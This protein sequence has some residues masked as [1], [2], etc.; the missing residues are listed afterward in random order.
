MRRKRVGI[1]GAGPIGL[2]AAFRLSDHCSVVIWESRDTVAGNML[3]WGWVR[4]FSAMSLN[5]PA[6]VKSELGD[7][8][9]SEESYLTGSEFRELVLVPLAELLRSRGVVIDLGARVVCV[10]RGTLLKGEGV[11]AVGDGRRKSVPFRA[12]VD[13]DGHESYE[14]CDL[15]VDCS[16]TYGNG[17]SCGA[18]GVA[19]P[20]ERRAIEL[21]LMSRVIPSTFD[22]ARVAVVGS[23]YSA[24]T[25]ISKMVKYADKVYWLTRHVCQPYNL[26]ADDPL[27]QR[28]ELARLGNEI[29]AG[30]HPVVEYIGGAAI[31]AI[32]PRD[33]DLDLEIQ[34]DETVRV[35]HNL[36]HVYSL[37]GFKPDQKLYSELHMHACYAS[38][39]PIK[40]ASTLLAASAA[41]DP[42]AAADCL[43]QAA[44]GP[45]TL[46]NPEPDF[47]ILGMKSYGR[48]SSFLFRVGYE[49]VDL[50][51]N[52][53]VH[54]DDGEN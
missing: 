27:P 7:L 20:G 32:R 49:Q 38:D 51:Y 8:C 44:P 35:I 24:I 6:S 33:I 10:G 36:D 14:S 48:N 30:T 29:S 4:L 31:L 37:C 39:G 13:R 54:D 18:G 9:P 53:L 46:E 1:I 40:L 17:V 21:G 12:L 52:K 22:K 19:A 23:G 2:Y 25:A 42:G 45:A 50:L 11:A 43:K 26:V 34:V 47:Y 41:A 3:D 16:G 28:N 5:V 15:L